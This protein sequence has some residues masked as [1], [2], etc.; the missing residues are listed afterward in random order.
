MRT[1]VVIWWAL[2]IR[3]LA[4]ILLGIAAFVYTGVTIAVVVLLFAAYLVV[5]G[6][7]TLVVGL[8]TR[9][10]WSGIQGVLTIAAGLIAWRWPGITALVLVVLTVVWALLTGAIEI[11]IALA[12]RRVISG[13]LMLIVGGI[14]SIVFGIVLGL[15]L[16]VQPAAA[17]ATI[18]Y[19]IGAYAFLAGVVYLVLAFRLRSFGGRAF[20]ATT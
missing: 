19:I 13:E 5:D 3:G 2:L 7:F 10:W 14:L 20:V 17:L 15:L 12:L 6:I 9:S 1:F 4:G 8:R 16:A 18:V 11:G